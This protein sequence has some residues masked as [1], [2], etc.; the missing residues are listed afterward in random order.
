M[1]HFLSNCE[2]TDVKIDDL[3]L[4][5]YATL[6]GLKNLI[7]FLNRKQMTYKH[8]P[9]NEV[10]K[11]SFFE[12]YLIRLQELVSR[13]PKELIGII[14]SLQNLKRDVEDPSTE[15]FQVLERAFNYHFREAEIFQGSSSALQESP[16]KR[17]I[18]LLRQLEAIIIKTVDFE[19]RYRELFVGKEK[20]VF[21]PRKHISKLPPQYQT[22][23]GYLKFIEASLRFFEELP[24][25]KC[26][27]EIE[28]EKKTTK[29]SNEDNGIKTTVEFTS[30]KNMIL[31][32][33]K[34][35]QAIIAPKDFSENAA[36]FIEVLTQLYSQVQVPDE[37]CSIM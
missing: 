37:G 34:L 24:A 20:K 4:I 22:P 18:E 7:A 29:F 33:I 11:R 21:L 10:L 3:A 30:E 27:L 15:A 35:K 36:I 14:E 1:T 32:K 6:H 9:A 23:S 17:D 25:R 2:L 13:S 8:D 19:D 26:K 16:Y 5:D 12:S 28:F 31:P